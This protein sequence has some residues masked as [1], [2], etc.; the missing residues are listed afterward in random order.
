M[1]RDNWNKEQLIVALNLYWKIPYNKISGSSNSVIKRIAPIINRTPAALAYK[2]MN[3]TSLDSEKQKIGNKGKS[4]ASSADK[5]IWHEYF[6]QWEALALDSL[7]ILSN[8]Q[9][10][11]IEE[12]LDLDPELK[13][14]E[15]KEKERIVKTRVNQNDFRQRILASYNQKCSITGISFTSLLVASH[16]IPWSK[17]TKERLNPKNGICLNN[18]HDKAFDKGLITITTDFKVKLSD[19]ILKKRKED[20]VQKYFIEYENKPI[21]LPERFSPSIEFLEYHHQNIFNKLH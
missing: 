18:I 21:I 1:A 19:A 20:S 2:L 7:V 9:N 11:P 17:N 3:F 5:E 8:L 15:G 16:I 10:K 6:G 13:F 12:T 4:A 14:A